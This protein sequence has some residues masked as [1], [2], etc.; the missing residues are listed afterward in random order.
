[1]RN[2]LTRVGIVGLD[3]H[4]PVF[5]RTVREAEEDIGMKVVKAMPVTSVM[6]SAQVLAENVR[7][8]ETL[9]IEI[10]DTAAELAEGVDGILI[11]HDDGSKH[12]ELVKMFAGFGKPLFV[13]KPLE[14]SAVSAQALVAFCL[15][16]RCPVFSG[17][18]L[19]FSNEMQSCLAMADAGRIQSAM[20]YAPYIL[21]PSMPGWIYYAIH[22]VEPLYALMGQGCI[23]VRCIVGEF[24]PLAV[25]TWQDGRMGIAKAN[26]RCAHGYGFTAWRE[27]TIV[28]TA[29]D[30]EQIYPELL[31]RIQMFIQEGKS[32][33]ELDES[34][35]VIAFLEAANESMERDGKAV[36]L[37]C[38]C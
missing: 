7:E 37:A 10:V 27:N 2:A 24:G 13:D 9:G 4:G 21:K 17:S 32:P 36:A 5:A 29:V 30:A 19:R 23:D 16:H 31:K 6:V 14:A 38:N 11:L 1:M 25:G 33:V 20:T 3:G 22:A 28:S 15:E 34:V 8:T 26:T 18:S 35:E 12:L